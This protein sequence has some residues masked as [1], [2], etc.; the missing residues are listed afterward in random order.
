MRAI[1]SLSGLCREMDAV[2]A[3]L[4]EIGAVVI[5]RH[6]SPTAVLLD[7]ARYEALLAQLEDL[8]DLA[9]L[10]KAVDEPSRPYEEFLAELDG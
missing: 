2:L 8:A 5:T 9:S 6:G 3:G 1:I 7:F 4:A 10:E